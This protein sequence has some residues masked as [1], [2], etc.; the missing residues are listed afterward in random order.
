MSEHLRN[1]NRSGLTALTVVLIFS[2][3]I[4]NLSVAQA[5]SDAPALFGDVGAMRPALERPLSPE[6]ARARYV[7]VNIGMLFSDSGKPLNKNLLP[8]VTLNLFSEVTYTGIVTRVQREYGG[9]TWTGRLQG[10]RDGYFHLVVVDNV[11]IAHVASPE[12][13]YEV[14][15]AGDGLYQAVQIDQ[16]KFG[17][18]YPGATYAS[19]GRILSPGE[20]DPNADSGSVIDVLVAYTDDA[21]IAEGSTAAMKARIAL[22]MT[23][24]NTAY[25]RSGVLT[26]LR[27]VHVEEYSYTET[28]NLDADLTRFRG[29]GDGFFDTVHSLRNIYGA[30][31]LGLL[32][33]NGGAGCGLA[34][35]IMAT[36]TTAFQAT[37]R[38]C[39]TGNY[40]FG[41]EFGHL[42]NARHDTYVDNTPGYNHG[43]VHPFS[44][45]LAERVRSIMA[46]NNQC[47]ESFGY[48]CTRLQYWSNPHNDMGVI[49]VSEN[50]RVLTETAFTVANFRSSTIDSNFF[51]DFN[52]SAEDWSSING[53]WAIAGGA[54][55]RSLGRPNLFASASHAGNY[56]DLTY[57]VRMRRTGTC[58]SCA[59]HISIRGLP[60]PL[61]ASKRWNKEYKFAYSNAGTF[62]VWRVNGASVVA[63]KPWTASGAIVVNNWNTLKV[64][65]VGTSLRFYINNV[66]VWS[67]SDTSFKTGKVGVAISR[68]ASAGTLDVD[69]ARLSNTPTADFNPNET[70]APGME[71][72][73]GNDRKS[74]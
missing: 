8:R 11:F 24:T 63:L 17:E 10:K 59:N 62:S 14:S 54:S 18:D 30:D 43:W 72:L 31:M 49:G 51:S 36:A 42:Q 23:E 20:L 2:F 55:Y 58:T 48:S 3:L 16:S 28:G 35:A 67:G 50:H 13:I 46:Y 5:Q 65:A 6:V 74:P 71:L 21:R 41:H 45:V 15:W 33:E 19:P 34:S 1:Q 32:V 39:A 22:A 47:T 44:T 68:D 61:D 38:G 66:L 37:D 29:T 25:A 64:V 12:G 60:F 7:N 40:T 57:E 26:R 4:G 70:V 9:F 52:G 56:G 53:A 73:G 27:L 69:W